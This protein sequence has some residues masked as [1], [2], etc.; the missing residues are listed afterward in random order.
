MTRTQYDTQDTP[1]DAALTAMAGAPSTARVN[2]A[3]SSCTAYRTPI[4]MS[5][6]SISACGRTP[7]AGSLLA[8]SLPSLL[9]VESQFLHLASNSSFG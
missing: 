3:N 6:F 9:Q 8:P 1:H 2:V 4:A 7:Y 5:L